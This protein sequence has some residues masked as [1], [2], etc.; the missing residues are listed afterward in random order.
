M[1]LSRDPV[2]RERQLAALRRNAASAPPAPKGNQRGVVHGGYARVARERLDAKA[3][4]VYDALASDAPVRGPDGDLPRYDSPLLRLLA[5]TLCR[6]EDVEQHIALYGGFDPKTREAR[7]VLEVE[8]HLRREAA[9]YLDR[10][11]MS[12][13]SRARLGVDLAR[14]A[15]LATAMSEPDPERR[16]ALLRE[17]GVELDDG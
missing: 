5:M 6:L 11:G 4:D 12:P 7:G 14:T 16:A 3:R 13:R 8:A 17:A 2:K 9:D 10:L 1:G 15:D